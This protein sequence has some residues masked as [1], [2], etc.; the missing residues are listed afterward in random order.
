[1]KHQYSEED[2]IQHDQSDKDNY[3]DHRKSLESDSECSANT[4]EENADQ[5]A[6]QKAKRKES[7]S[8][9]DSGA[10][11]A[12]EFYKYFESGDPLQLIDDFFDE[13]NVSNYLPRSTHLG[14]LR[15]GSWK[16]RY[17]HAKI[18][19]RKKASVWKQKDTKNPAHKNWV[20]D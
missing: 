3:S 7:S 17:Y 11:D 20:P 9:E 8:E 12:R 13:K 6:E 14:K 4:D 16:E 15:T 10:D 5:I 1:M 18:A 19:N 2:I